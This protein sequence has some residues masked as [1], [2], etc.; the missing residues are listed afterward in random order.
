MSIAEK[1]DIIINAN[2]DKAVSA[3]R[4]VGESAAKDLGKAEA[5]TA[6]LAS[7][8][9]AAGLSMMAAGGVLIAGAM[10]WTNAAEEHNL[11]LAK[12]N[13][14]LKNSPQ[15]AGA[16]SRAFEDQAKAIQK[17]T[18]ASDEA[19]LGIQANLGAMGL[20]KDQILTLTP[21][22]VDLARRFGIDYADAAKRVA[23]AVNGKT[24][25]LEG[26]VGVID[27]TTY[28]QD[29][30]RA[31]TDKL[32]ESVK[33]FAQ[34]PQSLSGQLAILKNRLHDT[35]E[36]AGQ[37]A[38]SAFQSLFGVV[39]WGA[40]RFTELGS[41]T[42]RMVGELTAYAGVG[43]TVA[44][45]TSTVIG[46]VM[47]MHQTF[48]TATGAVKAFIANHGGLST[49]AGTVGKLGLAAAGITAAGIAFDQL[50]K[51]FW[52]GRFGKMADD[53]DRLS[54]S[55]KEL[56]A[57]NRMGVLAED[58][59]KLKVAFRD[60]GADW[61]AWFT[62]G[63]SG[64]A[65]DVI[66]NKNR[67]E[68]AQQQ[69]EAVDQALKELFKQDPTQAKAAFEALK[70]QLVSAGVSVSDVEAG[71]DDYLTAVRDSQRATS[72][73]AEATG[74]LT[75]AQLDEQKALDDAVAAYR[76][77]TRA[78]DELKRAKDE[79][80]G[81]AL[82]HHEL[83]RELR[84]TELEVLEAQRSLNEAYASGDPLRAAQAEQ[85]LMDVYERKAELLAKNAAAQ[86]GLNWATLDGEQKARLHA[87][88]LMQVA[89]TLAPDSPLRK[90]LEALIGELMSMPTVREIDIFIRGHA[91]E[92]IQALVR[93]GV[94][95]GVAASFMAGLVSV[96]PGRASGG[97]VT[98]GQPYV[99]GERG[100]ELFVPDVSGTV[101]P[102]PPSSGQP[103]APQPVHVSVEIN[104]REIA[105]ALAELEAV[106]G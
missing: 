82:S 12:L 22:V 30:F 16:T 96:L 61:K 24:K 93:G 48:S 25:G 69:I 3:F 37:G 101:V 52:E 6:Q 103:V 99:V 40:D 33:G 36:E 54:L 20:T 89:S 68:E 44:G 57:G 85:S 31:V 77:Q 39:R 10:R 97:P 76:E 62:S 106:R 8:F 71:F 78:V 79:L 87:F 64:T 11:A 29:R 23:M 19:V 104:G 88:A 80:Y 92:I 75:Q 91:D 38:L 2:P 65:L 43:L 42:Q 53:A 14:T 100:K 63:G 67:I 32:N 7:K 105:R 28:A 83:Q 45:V 18:V 94:S 4:K 26:L 34:N 35:S 56:A 81:Q 98:A 5:S 46:Q 59:D 60:V 47:R 41:G 17:I 84:K 51:R 86:Q 66:F 90:N 50:A 13:N 15:L 70:A 58:F 55:L 9:S 95:G 72:D 49:F 102:L 27:R 74:N 21:L 1:L 73:A